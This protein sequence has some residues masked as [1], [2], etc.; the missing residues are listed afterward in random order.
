M[1]KVPLRW[2]SYDP[3]QY[4]LTTT[5]ICQFTFYEPFFKQLN[6]CIGNQWS[7]PARWMSLPIFGVC[8]RPKFL[9]SVR[10]IYAKLTAEELIPQSKSI[11]SS[12]FDQLV[13]IK[14]FKH[15]FHKVCQHVVNIAALYD[16]NLWIDFFGLIPSS[17]SIFWLVKDLSSGR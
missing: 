15:H 7:V 11:Y 6:V 17:K 14:W 12:W 13:P 1:Q 9:T 3:R 10:I 8:N 4:F 5:L 16:F 2:Q